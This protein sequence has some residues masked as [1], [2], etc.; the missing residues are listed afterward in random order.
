MTDLIERETAA[1][2]P[3]PVRAAGPRSHYKGEAFARRLRARHAAERRFRRAGAAAVAVAAL[4]LVLLIGSIAARGA[5]AFWE[6]RIR[7]EVALDPAEVASGNYTAPLRRALHAQFP[8]VTDRAGRRVLNDLLSSGA[9]Y[10]LE[11]MVARDPAMVGTVR[12]V[13]VRA[14]DEIDQ[15]AK[16]HYRR[17]L[18]EGE[19]GLSDA[20]VAAADALAAAGALA[21]GFNTT[22]FTAGDSREPEQAGM[23]GAIVG[24]LLT[25]LVTMLL[26]VPVGIAAAVYLEEFAPKNRWTGL[27]EVN[28]NNLAAVPSIIFGLLGLAVFLGFFGLPR[29]APLVGGLVM[30][31]MT[32]PVIIIAARAALRA[33]PPSIRDA[34]LAIGASPLQTVLHH[35]LPLALP[36]I[37]TGTIIGMARALG[38]TAP[39]LMIGMVAFIVDIPHG[40]TDSATV[41]PVQIYMWAD[42][43][44]RAFTE[45]TSAAIL[46]LL[47]FLVLLNGVAVI[48]RR[49]FER[50]W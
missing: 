25:L 4:M 15:L 12:T 23:G 11:A 10:E 2:P 28:I 33:V 13:W 41:L 21:Q 44:E 7:L 47:G 5:S 26:S 38:E 29:S 32:L 8:Q 39:L 49:I 19:R 34:A 16:G 22:L 40:L 20:K 48:L 1:V 50:R 31:L 27:I 30:A 43:P 35:V 17:D 9:P 46:V 42:S 37:L 18:P 36:G 6:T 45:R 14:D 24:S 3:A